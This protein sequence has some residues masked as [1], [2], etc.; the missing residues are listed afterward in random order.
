MGH[1]SSTFPRERERPGGYSLRTFT[2][3]LAR[4]VPCL[5]LASHWYT[6]LS[7]SWRLV[8]LISLAEILPLKVLPGKTQTISEDGENTVT[9]E[10]T[11]SP[12]CWK[13]KGKAHL[14]DQT[15]TLL[16]S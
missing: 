11:V 2:L 8:R 3:A 13:V 12:H 16:N 4:M 10:L 9:A 6:A 14:Q 1:F 7:C 15:G 5:L